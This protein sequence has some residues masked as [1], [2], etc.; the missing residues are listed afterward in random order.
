MTSFWM[1]FV[2]YQ[3]I[4]REKGVQI[5]K[6]VNLTIFEIK[7]S[8][9]LLEIFNRDPKQHSFEKLHVLSYRFRTSFGVGPCK[10]GIRCE[11]PK[12]LWDSRPS[13]ERILRKR[14]HRKVCFMTVYCLVSMLPI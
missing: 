13:G 11:V 7:N 6:H 9:D 2:D 12:K 10:S 4:F 5:W 14:L 1:T 3:S 8:Y